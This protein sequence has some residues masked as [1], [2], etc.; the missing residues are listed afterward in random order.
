MMPFKIT[1]VDKSPV[2]RAK[3][4]VDPVVQYVTASIVVKLT[5]KGIAQHMAKSAK[6]VVVITTS[7]LYVKVNKAMKAVP[8]GS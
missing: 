4:E 1:G 6:N 3:A 5:I 2:V 7:K 8:K